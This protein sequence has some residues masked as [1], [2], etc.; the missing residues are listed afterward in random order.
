MLHVL[1]Y[2]PILCSKTVMAVTFVSFP[3]EYCVHDKNVKMS[4]DTNHSLKNDPH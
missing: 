2:L 4:H 3:Q 1:I